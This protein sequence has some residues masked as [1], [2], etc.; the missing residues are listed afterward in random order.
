LFNI[1]ECRTYQAEECFI[2]DKNL[3]W[4]ITDRNRQTMQSF[5]DTGGY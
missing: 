5:D 3:T 4:L 2:S 1:S